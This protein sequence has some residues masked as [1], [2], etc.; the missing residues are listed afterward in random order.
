MKKK[1]FLWSMLAIMMVAMLGV[2]FVA[3]GGDDGDN[4]KGVVGTW[5]GQEGKRY[6]TLTFKGDGTGTYISR[7]NDSYSGMETETG[8]FTYIMEGDNKG[9]I[10]IREYDSYSGYGYE[11]VYFVIEGKTM[12]LYDDYY[13]DDLEWILIKQ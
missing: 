9:I 11:T 12:S 4:S 6:L 5:S 1:N 7:Y 8:T 10:N 13:Y 2:G 3:C